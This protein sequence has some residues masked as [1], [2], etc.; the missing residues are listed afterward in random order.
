MKR[1]LVVTL[2]VFLVIALSGCAKKKAVHEEATDAINLDTLE[3]ANVS[4]ASTTAATAGAPTTG[5]ALDATT[6]QGTA[7]AVAPVIAETPTP[8]SLEPTMRN[9][10]IAL[11]NA[12]V[13]SGVADGKGGAKTKVAVKDFQKANGLTADGKVGPKTWAKLSPYLSASGTAA[14]ASAVEP[15]A[16][17]TPEKTSKA[18]K[19]TK[20]VKRSVSE[21]PAAQ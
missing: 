3:T 5:V 13:Y 15:T 1:G 4:P 8:S 10:Q 16:T 17:P 7:P 6:P 19:T 21:P 20:R 2:S 12:G 18:R 14:A 11:K 9:I